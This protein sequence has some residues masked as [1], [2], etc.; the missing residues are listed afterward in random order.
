MALSIA[1]NTGALMAAASATS[2]NKDMETSMERLSTGKRINSAKDDAAGVAI[3]SRLTSEIRGTNQSIRNAQDAQGLIGTAEGAQKEVENILQRMRELAVQ[4]ASDTNSSADR[5]AL[6]NEIVQLSSEI[7]R[8]AETTTWAGQNL[9]D[10]SFISKNF[11]IGAARGVS[12]TVSQDSIKASDIGNHTVDTVAVTSAAA[13]VA[14]NTVVSTGFTV[15]GKA[16]SAVAAVTAGASAKTLAAAVNTD[17]TSTGVK[18][19][20]NTA[21]RFALV[22]NPDTATTMTL[23]GGG[24]AIAI[25]ATITDNSDL[26]ALLTAINT[27]SGST[28]VSA[29]FDGSDK[30]ALILREADGDNISITNFTSLTGVTNRTATVEKQSNFEGTAFAAGVTLTS[31]TTDSTVVTG[32]ARLSSSSSFVTSGGTASATT[33]YNGGLAGKTSAL[34]KVSD[35]SVTTRANAEAALGVIDAALAKV[36]ESRGALGAYS[37]R[38]DSTVSNLTNTAIQLEGGR[39]RIEDADFAAE[40]TTLAKSQILQQASTAMLAQANASKQNVLS[41]LQG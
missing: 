30:S 1:T 32:V 18:A 24:S 40:S 6:N 38:L 33:G 2:V 26:S 11:Q 22:G 19:V 8:I 31:G 41:L 21:I 5:S 13:A 17:T 34:N 16:G 29:E 9:L 20:A 10:G 25:S 4:S 35:V 28:G 14:T 23:Q 36:N 37:S 12:L 27:Y 39:G 7:D 15:L 3:A